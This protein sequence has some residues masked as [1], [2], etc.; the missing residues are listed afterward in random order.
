[1]RAGRLDATKVVRGMELAAVP[2]RL[3]RGSA[4]APL[5]RP[6]PVAA[7]PDPREEG[8]RL[9]LEQGLREGREQGLLAGREEGLR[10]GCAQAAEEIRAAVEQAVAEAVL[11]LREEQ[12]RLQQLAQS[13]ATAVDGIEEAAQDELVALCY[14]TVCRVLG[15]AVLQPEVVR[16]HLSH[17]R[18]LHK[19]REVV[20]HVHPQDADLLQRT[21][22]GAPED[23][24]LR[25]AADPEVALGG[26]L[27]KAPGGALDARL[28]TMLLACKTALLEARAAHAQGGSMPE[29]AP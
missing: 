4:Q 24:D 5:P 1:M 26:C 29:I 19:G 3:G 20:L 7:Q 16:Q 2:L 14:E 13:L 8:R 22:V 25:W 21:L 9:G 11:P 17:L 6:V 10:E 28:E 15:E 27:L 23:G 18:S 12:T